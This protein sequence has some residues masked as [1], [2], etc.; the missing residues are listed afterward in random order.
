MKTCS[1]KALRHLSAGKQTSSVIDPPL[2][3][4]PPSMPV[5]PVAHL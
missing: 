2:P 3:A 4:L 1:I 5:P